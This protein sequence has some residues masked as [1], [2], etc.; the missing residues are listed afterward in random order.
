[1]TFY[2]FGQVDPASAFISFCIGCCYLD[3]FKKENEHQP[4]D[5]E[6]EASP[7]QT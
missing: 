6:R 7:V 4:L 2:T 1:M 3:L 5:G